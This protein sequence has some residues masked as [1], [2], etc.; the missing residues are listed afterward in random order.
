[1]IAYLNGQFLLE[2]EAKIPIS[3]RGLLY[4]DGFFETIRIHNGKPFRWASHSA[5]LERAHKALRIP[6]VVDPSIFKGVLRELSGR[7]GQPEAIARLHITRGSGPRGYS[8]RGANSPTV[9]L[10]MHTVPN[11]SSLSQL[12]Y[13]TLITS[14]SVRLPPPNPISSFKHANRLLQILAR[15]EA[16]DHAAN[17]AVVLDHLGTVAETSSA[18]IFWVRRGIVHTPPLETNALPGVSRSLVIELCTNKRLQLT[19]TRIRSDDLVQAEA[20]FLSLSSS[21]I[22]AVNR[23]DGL[24]I[25]CSATVRDLH[26]AYLSQLEIECPPISR[27]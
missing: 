18:N 10:T 7:N 22:V 13:W 19:E 21:G 26:A 2:E 14:Q 8:V 24:P 4:G 16:D 15:M 17:D 25:P 3:D 6:I 9:L 20:V 5:R 11:P 23:I 27:P 12:Q 1:M